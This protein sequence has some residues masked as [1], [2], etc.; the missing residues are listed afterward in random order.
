MT[1]SRSSETGGSPGRASSPRPSI[2]EM[3]AVARPLRECDEREL[4]GPRSTWPASAISALEAGSAG[5]RLRGRPRSSETRGRH[6]ADQLAQLR[7]FEACPEPRCEPGRLRKGDRLG[8]HRAGVPLERRRPGAPRTSRPVRQGTPVTRQ[9]SSPSAG[10]PTDQQGRPDVTGP[11]LRASDGHARHKDLRSG[12]AEPALNRPGSCWRRGRC[13][14]R[15]RRELQQRAI[16]GEIER[17]RHVPPASRAAVASTSTGGQFARSPRTGSP[18]IRCTVPNVADVTETNPHHERWHAG[19]GRSIDWLPCV[20]RQA[21][22]AGPFRGSPWSRRR[23]SPGTRTL[24]AQPGDR[25]DR[26]RQLVGLPEA[27]TI[28][29]WSPSSTARDRR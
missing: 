13:T 6:A 17:R 5:R 7:R 25:R 10:G 15:R 29:D 23:S 24:V 14:G 22:K 21:V 20:R 26:V 1:A 3:V 12:L 16:A 8:E 4:D 27:A 28:A 9:S 19:G 18:G 2:A 11:S